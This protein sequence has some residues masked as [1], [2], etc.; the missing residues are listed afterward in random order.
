MNRIA[1]VADLEAI[2]GRP[3][4]AVTRKQI[5]ALDEGCRRVLA[6]APLAGFGYRDADGKSRTTV[7]GGRPGFAAVDSPRRISLTPP[8]GEPPPVAGSGAS[9]VFLLPGVGEVLRLNGSVAGIGER[10]TVDVREAYVHCARAV[11]RSG[12]WAAPRAAPTGATRAADGPLADPRVAAFLAATPFLIVSSVDAGGGGDSS[13]RGDNPGFLRVLDGRTLALP[14]RR[15][16]KRAD[17]FHNLLEDERLSAVALVP[18]RLEVL[19]LSGTARLT[20]DPQLL[21]TMALGTQVPHAALLFTVSE[22]GVVP[23]PAV[24]SARPWDRSRH[25]DLTAVPDLNA[26]ATIHL[27]ANAPRGVTGRLLRLIARRLDR[28]PRLTRRLMAAL[29]SRQLRSEGYGAVPGTPAAPGRPVRVAE[30]I[31]E[32]ADATTLVLD[33]VDGAPFD[34]LPGQFFTLVLTIGGR[35][36]RR[37]YSASSV[38]GSGRLTLTVKRTVDG[39]ASAHVHDGVRPGD[40]LRLLGPS[41]SFRVARPPKELVLLAAGSGITP[42]MSIVRAT[43]A[44][45][46]DTRITLFYGNRTEA[47]IIFHAALTDLARAH[48]DR[49]RVHHVLSRPTPRWNGRRGRLDRQTVRDALAAL[50]PGDEAHFYSCGPAGMSAGVRD[51]LD[52]LGVPADRRHEET[53]AGA[54]LPAGDGAEQTMTVGD[55]GTV[56]VAAGQTLLEAG[57]DAALPMPYSCTVGSCGECRVRLRDG[58]VTMAEPNCLSPR[59]RAGGYI[60]TCVAR[61]RTGTTVEIDG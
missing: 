37:A 27:A 35:T 46:A 57:L 30:V 15:G 56:T 5:D 14:D 18:G 8:A 38:P 45:T 47:D 33:S 59:E 17:T 36:V 39:Y 48:P 42:M 4:D 54:P 9:F 32:T 41:G 16:N 2:I 29:F 22:A 61:P 20:D 25:V 28:Y 60:L 34:F 53:F 50:A 1:T 7:V 24:E 31:R 44:G 51:V 21:R 13:P 12:L 49:L 19:R 23:S 55:L 6:A 11:G 43:L 58:E 10:L 40:E 3:L 26:L 52:E